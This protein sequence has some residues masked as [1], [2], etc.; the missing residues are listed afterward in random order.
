MSD[1]LLSPHEAALWLR[2]AYD[3]AALIV[4]KSSSLQ[5]AEQEIRRLGARVRVERIG[6]GR[7]TVVRPY[8][9]EAKQAQ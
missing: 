2:E 6:D 3:F 9:T 5:E 4:R 7:V 1:Q 8:V